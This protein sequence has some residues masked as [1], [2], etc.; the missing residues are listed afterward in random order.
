MLKTTRTIARDEEVAAAF[1]SI[2]AEYPEIT[3]AHLETLTDRT[4][5]IQHAIYSIPNRRTG[6]TTDDNARALIVAVR[7]YDSTGSRRALRLVSTFLSFIHYAQVPSGKFHN[8]MSFDQIFLDGEGSE[9]CQGRTIW[10]LGE[11]LAADIHSNVKQVA[12]NLLDEA[13]WVL[14]QCAS[15]RGRCYG[16]IGL[17]LAQAA[18]PEEELADCIRSVADSIVAHYDANAEPGWEWFEP[19]LTYSNAV[20]PLALFSAYAVLGDERYLEVAARS[21]SFLESQC[22]LDGKLQIIGCNGWYFRGRERAWYDQQ[23]VDAMAMV[24][25]GIAGFSATGERRYL[26]TARISFDWFFG[27]NSLREVLHDPV[28]GGCFDGLMSTGRNHNMGSESTI[29]ALLSQIAMAPFIKGGQA[30]FVET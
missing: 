14:P 25:G 19:F 4:G 21:W 2:D 22:I 12:K 15:T 7:H 17:C 28:T 18:E 13:M 20:L 26:D 29:A 5:V 11:C 23:P 8:F 30:L 6:Y 24:L 10:A 1:E 27:G 9:D 3:L 16:L